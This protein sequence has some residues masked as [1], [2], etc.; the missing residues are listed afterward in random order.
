MTLNEYKHQALSDLIALKKIDILES[1]GHDAIPDADN[2]DNADSKVCY[3]MN[4]ERIEGQISQAIIDQDEKVLG[5]I[6]MKLFM[7][8]N[9][10]TINEKAQELQDEAKQEHDDLHGVNEL[11]LTRKHRECGVDEND[12]N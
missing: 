4:L 10:D 12:F 11:E 5:A 3:A 6:I 9:A 1:L 2:A 8:Y 7:D